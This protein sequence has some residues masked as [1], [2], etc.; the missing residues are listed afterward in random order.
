MWKKKSLQDCG[1]NTTLKFKIST[2]LPLV[3]PREGDPLLF[4][5]LPVTTLPNSLQQHHT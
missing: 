4:D 3:Q 2:V 5:R 1:L